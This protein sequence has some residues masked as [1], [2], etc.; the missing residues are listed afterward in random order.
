MAGAVHGSRARVAAH[1]YPEFVSFEALPRDE[2]LLFRE[3][4]E[5]LIGRRATPLT[6]DEY[7][8]A[9]AV[10]REMWRA[11]QELAMREAAAS[12]EGA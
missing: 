1:P 3:A 9:Y 2:Q 4:F 5:E 10:G 11:R 8:L 6:H 12:E 7:Q